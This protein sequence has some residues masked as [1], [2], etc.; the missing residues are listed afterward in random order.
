MGLVGLSLASQWWLLLAGGV[1]IGLGYG[2][3]TTLASS[4]LLAE[5]RRAV[6][7][8]LSDRERR[9]TC[10]QAMRIAFGPSWTPL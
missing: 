8:R 2:G 9:Q 1:A 4:S 6:L 3:A 10:G 5:G 7:D